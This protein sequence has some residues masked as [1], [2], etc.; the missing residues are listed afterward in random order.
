M[1]H[2][3]ANSGIVSGMADGV[4]TAQSRPPERRRAALVI[5]GLIAG[6]IM[7]IGA[8]IGA[9]LLVRGIR[10]ARRATRFAYA[11]ATFRL[12][13]RCPDCKSLIRSDATVCKR[14]GYR[15][16]PRPP[17][18]PRARRRQAATPA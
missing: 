12:Y 3:S 7:I 13:R 14:C 4:P 17:K 1:I 16:P 8:W 18:G 15:R 5:G 10:T 9:K 11:T 6:L 2:Q